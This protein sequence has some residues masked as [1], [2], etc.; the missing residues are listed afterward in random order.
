MAAAVDDADPYWHRSHM[1]NA[2]CRIRF[3]AWYF[4]RCAD[5]VVAITGGILSAVTSCVR[6]GVK[7]LISFP[8]LP[9]PSESV[10]GHRC[11]AITIPRDQCSVAERQAPGDPAS[12]TARLNVTRSIDV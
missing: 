6:D 11:P 7:R 10:N 8:V 5:Q 3:S 9:T 2:Q 4:A 12:A 1:V